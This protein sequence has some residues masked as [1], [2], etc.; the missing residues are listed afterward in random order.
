MG[1]F[2]DEYSPTF[3]DRSD[4]S[5]PTVLRERART[6]GDRIYLDVPWAGETYTYA[7]TLDIAERVGSSMLG[8]GAVAGDRVLL[9][10]P[11]CSAYILGWLGSSMAGLAEV[12]I[13]TAYRGSFLAHQVSTTSPKIAVIG[14][15]FAER[16]VE[17]PE[18]TTTVERF[19]LVGDADDV[20]A[21]IAT[22]SA[23]GHEARDWNELLEGSGDELPDVQ[24]RDLGSI[25]FTSGTTGLSK[26][27]MMPQAHMYLFAD[28]CVSLTRLTDADTFMSTGP[29][30]HGNSQFLAAYPALIAGAH[31]VLQER[32]SATEWVDQIRDS[33]ATV[34]NFVGV[35]MDFVWQ[36]DP[37]PADAS[38][39]LRCI[40]AAPTASSILEPFKERF[41]V[42]AFVEVFGLTETCMPILTPYGVDRPE[43]AAGK[44]NAD[45][46]DIRLVDS[47]TDEEV[48]VGE[49]GELVVRARY[50]WTTCQGYFAMPDKT[51]EVFRNL[52]FHTGDGLRRDEA[53]WYYFVDRLK[54]AIRRRGENISSY[55]VEQGMVA[56]NAIAEVAAIGVP[57]DNEA[58][59]DEVMIF[60]VA[61]PGHDL[62]AEQ[63]WEF[64][65]Q[66]LPSF[67]VPRYI[68]MIDALPKTPS[69]KVRKIELREHG[70]GS[71]THD[72]GPA[73]R[74]RRKK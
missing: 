48:P 55:E 72:R 36:Q 67:A 28:E 5:S 54:D 60:V 70:V 33:G 38:G 31:Y 29:L 50:P 12:P 61:E 53:G 34:T 57:A 65:D 44:L 42:E 24:A 56:H 16:F 58:G 69:E 39:R 19:Y 32:F 17:I 73:P 49:V 74:R 66:Q 40:F 68:Q 37:T 23:A 30:F 62:S 21:G 20:A 35:M 46:F 22:L 71:G 25:F 27:V 8:A 64:A 9:M 15:E 41:G 45:W 4:W 26:G 59:E 1:Q 10:L 51:T 43:G 3:P 52:W 63:V 6:H 14:P 47:E 7:E 2:Y 18:A 13:N 11:N